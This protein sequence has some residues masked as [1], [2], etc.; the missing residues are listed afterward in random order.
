MDHTPSP[1]ADQEIQLADVSRHL[2]GLF[3]RLGHSFFRLL[4]FLLRNAVIVMVLFVI[5]VALGFFMD[6]SSRSY[7]HVLIVSPNFGSTDYLYDKVALIGAK[8][9]EGD[10]VFLKKEV[11]IPR[12]KGFTSIEIEPIADVY[13]FIDNKAENFEM[14]KLMAEA[15]DIQKIIK[16]ELTAKNYTYHKIS[17]ETDQKITQANTVQ[18]LLDYLNDSEYFRRVQTQMQLNLEERLRQND[19][20]IGEIDGILSAFTKTSGKGSNDK[21]IYYNENTQL[22]DVIQTKDRLINSKGS[23]MVERIRMD[24][25]VKDISLVLNMRQKHGVQGMMKFILPLVFI[26]AFVVFHLFRRFYGRQLAKYKA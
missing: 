25:I 14:L 24:K 26:G 9:K 10:S 2:S 15:E 23:L 12:P 21:L 19:S 11:G 3:E 18:P 6:R 22:N 16:D 1:N 8:R 17:F 4:R 20:I 5:G 7:S 13:G